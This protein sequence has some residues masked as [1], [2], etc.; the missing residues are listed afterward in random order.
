MSWSHLAETRA[1]RAFPVTLAWLIHPVTLASL[2]LLLIND[3]L[4]KAAYPGP[5]TG[6]LSDV[7]GLVLLPPVLATIVAALA[8]RLPAGWAAAGAMMSTAVGFTL[9]KAA[10]TQR[11][12]P[13][14]R[15]A[16]WSA[17]R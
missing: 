15:G 4:L 3:H 12:S 5:L 17:R 13:R 2:I 9:V 6:K 8:V 10:G 11:R 7:A 16:P 14:R 1:G